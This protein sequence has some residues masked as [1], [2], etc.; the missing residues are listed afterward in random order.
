MNTDFL[1]Q[2]QWYTVLMTKAEYLSAC[3]RR[4]TKDQKAPEHLENRFRYEGKSVFWPFI[5]NQTMNTDFLIQLQWYTM[6]TD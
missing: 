4:S 2:L 3:G 6:L 1:I 5:L